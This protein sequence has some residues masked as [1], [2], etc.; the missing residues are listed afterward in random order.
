MS[1]KRETHPSRQ[2]RGCARKSNAIVPQKDEALGAVILLA[3]F[4]FAV[5]VLPDLLYNHIAP[6]K[7][8]I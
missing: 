7:G 4:L 8:W 3:L 1:K 2:A 6:T 5:L